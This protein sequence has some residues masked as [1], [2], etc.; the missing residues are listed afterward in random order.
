MKPRDAAPSIPRPLSPRPDRA[1]QPHRLLKPLRKRR[2][3]SRKSTALGSQSF[4]MS[5]FSWNPQNTS[6]F[7]DLM[8][9]P[10]NDYANELAFLM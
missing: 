9:Y 8:I 6:S 1:P 4:A 10:F 7:N 3:E 2:T 5:R